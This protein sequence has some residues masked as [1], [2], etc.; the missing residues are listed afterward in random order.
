MLLKQVYCN[1]NDNICVYTITNTTVVEKEQI[2][3]M[4]N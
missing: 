4:K 2:K 1:Y 3:K